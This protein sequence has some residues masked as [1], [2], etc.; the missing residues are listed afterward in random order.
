MHRAVH[1]ER[2]R[3]RRGSNLPSLRRN[4]DQS[5]AVFKACNMHN[6]GEPRGGEAWPRWHMA[7]DPTNETRWNHAWIHHNTSIVWDTA[8]SKSAEEGVN[9]SMTQRINE[10]RVGHHDHVGKKL[11]IAYRKT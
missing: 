6:S 3:F 11:S 7:V 2:R 8:V 1:D 10:D 9:R 4:D 5:V